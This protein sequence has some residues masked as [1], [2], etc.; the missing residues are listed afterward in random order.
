[1]LGRSGVQVAARAQPPHFVEEAGAS[2][3][4]KR[5][6]MRSCSQPRSAGSSERRVGLQVPGRAPAVVQRS[7]ACRWRG[8]LP[9]RAGCAAHRSAPGAARWRDRRAPAPRAAPASRA[10]PLRPRSRAQLGVGRRH[11][12]QPVEQRLEVQHGAAGQQHAA[13]ARGSRRRGAWRRPR[14][15]RR[16]TARGIADVDQVVRHAASCSARRL[17][18][19]DVHAAVDQRR[20]DADDLGIQRL[21]DRQRGAVLPAAVGPARASRRRGGEAVGTGGEPSRGPPAGSRFNAG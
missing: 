6:A 17:G 19:A 11:G 5:R 1:M 3:A 15:P 2:M 10:A 8:T 18:G 14:T 16:C 9:A 13:A 20:V 21:R 12:I 7:A 4:S